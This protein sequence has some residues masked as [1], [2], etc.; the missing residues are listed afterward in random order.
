[1]D[2]ISSQGL[3][4]MSSEESDAGSDERRILFKIEELQETTDIHGIY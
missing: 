1:M 2:Y 4:Y 3:C